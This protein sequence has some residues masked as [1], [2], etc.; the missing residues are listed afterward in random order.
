MEKN[1]ISLYQATGFYVNLPSKQY[2]VCINMK[3]IDRAEEIIKECLEENKESI[4][5]WKKEW[6]EGAN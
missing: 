2:G 6:K 1:F 3:D 4:I 5:V